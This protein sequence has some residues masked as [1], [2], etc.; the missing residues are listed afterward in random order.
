MNNAHLEG[1][2]IS[3]EATDKDFLV[4]GSTP[5]YRLDLKLSYWRAKR[6]GIEVVEIKA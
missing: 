2:Y 6:R 1:D 4:H 3:H 5:W